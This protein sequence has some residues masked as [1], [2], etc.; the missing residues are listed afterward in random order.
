MT[1]WFL[2]IFQLLII[3]LLLAQGKRSIFNQT[4]SIPKLDLSTIWMVDSVDGFYED[5][6]VK[7]IVRNDPKAFFWGK[8]LKYF[9]LHFDSVYKQGDSL[10]YVKGR[11]LF[12]NEIR[13]ING[14]FKLTKIVFG[15][16]VF[17]ADLDVHLR[18]T[19]LNKQY[20]GHFEGRVWVT[21]TIDSLNNVRYFD[22]KFLADGS[23][24][25]YFNGRYLN[26]FKF[27]KKCS[28]TDII[29]L[30]EKKENPF[31]SWWK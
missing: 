27:T 1:K 20:T 22:S 11:T 8:K 2:F 25:N 16:S 30:E 12:D 24:N 23:S 31:V 15:T 17:Y 3:Q 28:W 10:Y 21:F 4:D 7:R 6:R 26:R 9:Y 29:N 19:N 14:S 5:G 18:Q 13:Y